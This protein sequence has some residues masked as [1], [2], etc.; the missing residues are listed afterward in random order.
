MEWFRAI[1]A[2]SLIMACLIFQTGNDVAS[3]YGELFL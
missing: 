1:L 3:T 2:L